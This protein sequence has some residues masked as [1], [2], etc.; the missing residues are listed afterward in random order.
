[1]MQMALDEASEDLGCG[2]LKI[3]LSPDVASRIDGLLWKS[4]HSDLLGVGVNPRAFGDTD[5]ESVQ[6]NCDVVRQ[7]DLLN[8]GSAAPSLSDL[9]SKIGKSKVTLARTFV[10]LE[11]SLK[12]FHIYLHTFCGAGHPITDNWRSFVARSS[13][14]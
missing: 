9:Q 7:C 6:V 11:A 8:T 14:Q 5:P 2:N 13:R 10:E 3:L 1:M 4:S 12:M